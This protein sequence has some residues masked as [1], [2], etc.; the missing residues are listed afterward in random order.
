MTKKTIIETL[1]K[2]GFK[3]NYKNVITNLLDVKG[4]VLVIQNKTEMHIVT[5][6]ML[7]NN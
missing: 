7:E 5:K 3:A 1:R 6:A 4:Y 2:M